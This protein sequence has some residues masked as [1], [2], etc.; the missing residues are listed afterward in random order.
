MMKNNSHACGVDDTA[1]CPSSQ[2]HAF[3]VDDD[4]L[5]FVPG[6]RTR[7]QSRPRHGPL[8]TRSTGSLLASAQG[9]DDEQ[10]VFAGLNRLVKCG[11]N[12]DH[13]R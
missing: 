7:S 13:I 6:F 2:N 11:V 1:C 5:D 9:K 3:G 8:Q 10:R 12:P 4:L